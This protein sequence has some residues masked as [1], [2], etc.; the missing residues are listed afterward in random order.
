MFSRLASCGKKRVND[1]FV[2]FYAQG[3]T[4]ESRLGLT[5]SKK[6]G[7]AVVRNR[8]KRICREYFRLHRHDMTIPLDMNLVARK[9]VAGLT[10]QQVNQ[11]LKNLIDALERK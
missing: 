9:P 2:L 4:D 1:Q 8:I 5:V 10:S 11:S 3:K 7:S 6:V